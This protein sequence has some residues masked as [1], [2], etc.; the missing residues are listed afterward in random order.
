VTAALLAIALLASPHGWTVAHA[1]QVLASRTYALTDV[2]QPDRPQYELKFTRA[3]ARKLT[4][5]FR[6][7][8]L[9]H[10]TLT[11]GDVRVRFTF[12]RPGRITGFRGPPADTSQP[13]FPIRATFYYAWYPEAWFRDPI[14]PYTRF[15]P[16]LDYYSADNARHRSRP[17]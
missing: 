2:S 8:G 11:N 5:K 12:K 3:Q 6:F 15:E 9:A 4:A 16:S 17:H 7:D 1:R 13:A 10:D 14:F